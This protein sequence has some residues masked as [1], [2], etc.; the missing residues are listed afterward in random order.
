MTQPAPCG[1]EGVFRAHKTDVN[2]NNSLDSAGSAPWHR[3]LAL[4]QSVL[5]P[6]ANAMGRV[7]AQ[8]FFCAW[9]L[10]V[11]IAKRKSVSLM[12]RPKCKFRLHPV[13]ACLDYNRPPILACPS[14][15]FH[16][17]STWSFFLH[18]GKPSVICRVPQR[19]GAS[20]IQPMKFSVKALMMNNC[21]KE[22][23]LLG[24]AWLAVLKNPTFSTG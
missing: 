5:A 23:K 21:R 6:K 9:M 24:A 19:K 14:R 15:L 1:G 11:W 22:R 8:R 3:H 20:T 16:I 17:W 18:P 13:F 12:R 2:Q 4:S 7:T 10:S